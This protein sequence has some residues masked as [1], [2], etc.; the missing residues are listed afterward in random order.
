MFMRAC[1]YVCAC[2][3]VCECVC[4]RVWLCVRVLIARSDQ[5]GKTVL[6]AYRIRFFVSVTVGNVFG[7]EAQNP[8]F[9]KT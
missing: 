1:V 9:L 5:T 2:M 6:A 8:Y 4:E 3:C 7:N